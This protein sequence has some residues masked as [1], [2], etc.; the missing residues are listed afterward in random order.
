M[1]VD[2]ALTWVQLTCIARDRYQSEVTAAEQ[3]A[4]ELT[5]TKSR[6]RK[7]KRQADERANAEGAQTG[8][9]VTTFNAGMSLGKH[10]RAID[11]WP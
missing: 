7:R 1:E 8:V 3:R 4:I 10:V 9:P 5:T 11:R 6:G 2:T